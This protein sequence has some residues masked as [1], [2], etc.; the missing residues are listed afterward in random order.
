MSIF[1][2]LMASVYVVSGGLLLWTGIKAGT[3]SLPRNAWIGIRTSKTL[4]SDEA[5]QKGHKAA[6]GFLKA[7]SLPM[8]LGGIF[9]AFA[10]EEQIAWSSLVAVG[11]MLVFV[12]L[13]ARKAKAAIGDEGPAQP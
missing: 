1:N 11:V 13:A 7:S 9:F 5:W 2:I 8:I 12:I 6:A 10:T 3:E 4:S